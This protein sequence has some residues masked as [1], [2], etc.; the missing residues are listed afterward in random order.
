M[1][2]HTVHPTSGRDVQAYMSLY[3]VSCTRSV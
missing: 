1:E 3:V 2:A